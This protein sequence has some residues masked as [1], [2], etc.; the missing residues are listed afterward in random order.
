M[1]VRGMGRLASIGAISLLLC[2]GAVPEPAQAQGAQPR[3]QPKATA[4]TK[5]AAATKDASTEAA[6]AL[7]CYD[8][9]ATSIKP[10]HYA[11]GLSRKSDFAGVGP[12]LNS[13]EGLVVLFIK[14]VRQQT[15]PLAANPDPNGPRY[16]VFCRPEVPLE[17]PASARIKFRSPQTS[18]TVFT[19]LRA[20]FEDPTNDL[21]NWETVPFRNLASGTTFIP[22]PAKYQKQIPKSGLFGGLIKGYVAAGKRT[23]LAGMAVDVAIRLEGSQTKWPAATAADA[24]TAAKQ[25]KTAPP[26]QERRTPSS[27]SPS[28]GDVQFVVSFRNK[29]RWRDLRLDETQRLST[30]GYC[31]DPVIRNTEDVSYSLLCRPGPDGKVPIGI[32]GFQP[33]FVNQSEAKEIDL[34]LDVVA[35]RSPYPAAWARPSAFVDVLG[36]TL[37][38]VLQS[39]IVLDQAVSSAPCTATTQISVAA[40][41]QQK[42]EFPA[43]PCRA[44]DLE[45]GQELADNS[46]R[47]LSLCLAGAQDSR[48]I[49][50]GRVTCWW[51]TQTQRLPIT[52]RAQLLT[53]FEPVN[54]PLSEEMLELNVIRLSFNELSD[55]LVP[56]WPYSGPSPLPGSADVPRFVVKSV[57][58]FDPAGASCG[59]PRAQTDRRSMPNLKDAGCRAVPAT[60]RIL[61][62]QDPVAGGPP[63][64][65]FQPFYP[66]SYEIRR[67]TVPLVDLEQ[68]KTSLPICFG[69]QKVDEYNDRFRVGPTGRTPAPGVHVFNGSTEQRCS[70]R[71]EG[72]LVPFSGGGNQPGF[73]WPQM[74]TVYDTTSAEWTML[75]ICSPAKIEEQ[76][77]QPYLT[78]DLEPMRASGPRRVIVIANS[79]TL[80]R[81]TAGLRDA[82]RKLVDTLDTQNK[83]RT[84]LSPIS[85]YSMDSRENLREVFTGE[86]AARKPAEA[87]QKITIDI[88]SV[89]PKNPE[90]KYLKS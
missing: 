34:K 60:A 88:D 89:A 71:N 43:P 52:L 63:P 22:W 3:V 83:A 70:A 54:L 2:C 85:V 56:L 38:Q 81:N 21:R 11:L 59:Q 66:Q 75:T 35:F 18:E 42:V 86:L 6:A 27:T 69:Q 39:P 12:D 13:L 28:P 67:G 90:L 37:S 87:K 48:Q 47:V 16:F 53:G 19:A 58:Y 41:V 46:A 73:K 36:G 44:Y 51:Q 5:D 55:R 79:Q 68:L 49:N 50:S 40:I 24:N 30:F 25:V 65:A 32:R 10:T 78:F 17:G 20:A 23:L 9:P 8:Q 45:F 26:R 61:L 84:P 77:G 4:V 76:D 64:R 14:D 72:I 15:Y 7:P 82:L 29:D 62:A 33:V 31:D 74:A 1:G 80:Q 57:E